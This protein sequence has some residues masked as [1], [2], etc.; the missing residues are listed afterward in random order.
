[1]RNSDPKDD[2]A[3]ELAACSAALAANGFKAYCTKTV[4]EAA[5]L[6]LDELV[7]AIAPQSAAWGDS[8]T[9]QAT[10]VIEALLADPNIDLIRT[11]DDMVSGRR[12]SNGGAGRF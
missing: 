12:S 10:G 2:I 3:P 1:M 5:R 9:L 7:P 8:M 11:F 6:I 4:A